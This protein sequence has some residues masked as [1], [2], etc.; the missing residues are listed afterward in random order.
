MG[1]LSEHLAGLPEWQDD[2][3]ARSMFASFS[4]PREVNPEAWDARLN[5]WRQLL[6][7]TT[8]LGLLSDSVFSI[9]S[10]EG[11]AFL[12]CRQQITPLGLPDVLAEMRRRGLLVPRASMASR[13]RPL[14]EILFWGPLRHTWGW[15]LG[16]PAAPAGALVIP[17]LLQ[18]A[19]DAVVQHVG[20]PA[21][22]PLAPLF[23]PD[24]LR[25]LVG[26]LRRAQGLPADV[27]EADAC[28]LIEY[29]EARGMLAVEEGTAPERAIRVRR[30]GERGAL[31]ISEEHRN[32]VRLQGTAVRVARHVEEL[33]RRAQE[34][35]GAAAQALRAKD[36]AAALQHLRRSRELMAVQAQRANSLGTIETI[37]LRIEGA[38]SDAEVFEAYKAGERTL[39]SLVAALPSAGAV[40]DLLASIQEH[41]AEQTLTAQALGQTPDLDLDEDDLLAELAALAL[42]ALPAEPRAAEEPEIARLG[43]DM[44][45]L[46]IKS[47]S[48]PGE[49]AGSRAP[50]PAALMY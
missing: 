47:V 32:I 23:T 9:P 34:L 50:E 36:R 44:A 7:D 31:R 41:G 48:P 5:F 43:L 20:R 8:R 11:L 13:S 21:A 2:L 17:A 49:P 26:E 6:V 24:T 16:S 14:S 45:H 15:A 22:A 42:P 25:G 39:G 38:K 33:A 37:L 40:D 19:A 28:L 12:F 29:M 30:P 35:R 10:P 1:R 27:T 3:R 46:Q 18:A 4:Q